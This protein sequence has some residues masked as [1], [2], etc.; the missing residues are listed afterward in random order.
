MRYKIKQNI[1][2]WFNEGNQC[3]PYYCAGDRI[4]YNRWLNAFGKENETYLYRM[5]TAEYIKKNPNI[6]ELIE[7]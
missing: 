3:N 2:N 4:E 7:G 1:P 5:I 6:F